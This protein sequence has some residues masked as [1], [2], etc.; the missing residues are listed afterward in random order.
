MFGSLCQDTRG[1]LRDLLREKRVFVELRRGIITRDALFAAF[2]EE[3]QW[4]TDEIN[5]I[6]NVTLPTTTHANEQPRPLHHNVV[7]MMTCETNDEDRQRK[8]TTSYAIMGVLKAYNHPS[9]KYSGA[10]DDNLDS[11]VAFLWNDAI[12]QF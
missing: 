9:Q 12:K 2:Q 1:K 7:E 11:K 3:L 6:S 10:Q 4:P 8:L 5:Q